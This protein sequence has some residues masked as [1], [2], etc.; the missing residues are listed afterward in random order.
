MQTADR[1]AW[2]LIDSADRAQYLAMTRRGERK[3]EEDRRNALTWY[4][5]ASK[6]KGISMALARLIDAR[7]SAM[8]AGELPPQPAALHDAA[9]TV[10]RHARNRRKANASYDAAQEQAAKEAPHLIAEAR[11]A[12]G[13]ARQQKKEIL[14]ALKEF[15]AEVKS[16][17]WSESKAERMELM[18]RN[19]AQARQMIAR[20]MP[21][22]D[23]HRATGLPHTRL[24]KIVRELFAHIDPTAPRH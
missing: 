10:W 12:C 9:Y 6:V 16:V 4:V 18:R 22:D 13:D 5:Q 20:R 7:L 3:R 23:V 17:K 2:P 8:H 1:Q 14:A 24:I 19:V 21:L 11:Q 15:K